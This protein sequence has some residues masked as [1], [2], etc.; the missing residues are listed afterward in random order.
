MLGNEIAH[1]YKAESIYDIFER[2]LGLTPILLDS[3]NRIADYTQ[4]KIFKDS[5]YDR[6]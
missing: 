5:P 3:V 2:V 1:E 4:E 6:K